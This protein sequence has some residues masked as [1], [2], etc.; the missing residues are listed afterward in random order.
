MISFKV[1]GDFNKSE[2]FLRN[3]PNLSARIHIILERY[4]A[5]G[6]DALS[7]ATPIDTGLT[8]TDWSYTIDKTPGGYTL[9]WLNKN[10]AGEIPVVILIQ[11]GHGTKN[12]A[13]VE[14][15]D[16]INP[17][18][19]PLVDSITSEIWKEVSAL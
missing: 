8:A 5:R 14:G 10:M 11:Y 2:R 15:R 17:A 19:R 1:T 6:V 4:G 7:S 18:I 3:I 13:Y 9:S 16:F 12:G